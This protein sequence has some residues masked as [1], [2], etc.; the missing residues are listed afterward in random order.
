MLHWMSTGL[1]P[2]TLRYVSHK[3]GFSRWA[4]QYGRYHTGTVL[5]LGIFRSDSFFSCY[6]YFSNHKRWPRPKNDPEGWRQLKTPKK[7]FD[8]RCSVLW[9]RIQ[10]FPGSGSVFGIRIG[11]RIHTCKYHRLK[12]RQKMSDLRYL[13]T[14]QRLNW[15]KISLEWQFVLIV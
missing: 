10:E 11:I 8:S 15:L 13:W 1:S 6:T 12:W 4:S 2:C 14:I 9:I 3:K 7:G 5:Y